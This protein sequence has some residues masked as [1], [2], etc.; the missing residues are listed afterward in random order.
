M[1]TCVR[2]DGV[3]RWRVQIANS[4]DGMGSGSVRTLFPIASLF[5]AATI[6]SHIVRVMR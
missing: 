3:V 2:H 4:V 1:P 5:I 6:G